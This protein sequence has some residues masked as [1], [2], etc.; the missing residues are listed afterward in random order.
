[1]ASQ[2][3]FCNFPTTHPLFADAYLAHIRFPENPD[4]LVNFGA[5]F[6]PS[7]PPPSGA[8][9]IHISGDASVLNKVFST[10]LAIAGD[11][12]LTIPELTAAVDGLESSA[13]LQQIRE[14]RFPQVSGFTQGLRQSR[15]TALRARF[16]RT[17]LTLE[18]VGYELEK[19]LDK[20]AVI[21]PELGTEGASLIG[22]LRFGGEDKT[23]YGR[24][25]GGALGWGIGAAFGVSLALPDRQVVALSG[26]GG[27]MFGQS[28]S[29][30]TISRYDA[31]MLI[32]IANNHSYNET[33]NRNLASGGREFQAGKDMS[34]YL[35]NP[36]VDF[37]KMAGAYSIRAQKVRGPG[38][39]APAIETALKTLRDGRPFLLDVEIGRDGILSESTWFPA[40]SISS[41]RRKNA[42]GSVG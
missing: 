31:P 32:V 21:V 25:I 12:A 33:R 7:Y 20:D 29:L 30:W 8:R 10:D 22:Q 36:D 23:R 38:E 5:R 19:A 37:T 26:D 15:E 17:P 6:D 2:D 3:L 34:S 39:L 24:T 4:L 16:D 9:I 13:R 41:Q 28:D 27:F 18:R 11:L 14:S 35:G 1:V 40:Y 42:K